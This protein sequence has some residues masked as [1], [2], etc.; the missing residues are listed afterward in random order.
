MNRH[1]RSG[2]EITFEPPNNPTTLMRQRLKRAKSDDDRQE[3]VRLAFFER[4]ARLTNQ[5]L[6]LTLFHWIRSLEFDDDADSVTVHWPTELNFSFLSRLDLQSAFSLRSFLMHKTLSPEEH[7]EIYRLTDQQGIVI[8]ESLLNSG[9]LTGAHSK[10][11]SLDQ[12]IESG[13]RYQ[14]HPL[15]LGPVRQHLV[16]RHIIY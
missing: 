9:L 7:N 8:L 1:R 14:I 11:D 5:N 4:L 2:L 13:K 6:R 3:I 16:G 10:L 15:L 12:R